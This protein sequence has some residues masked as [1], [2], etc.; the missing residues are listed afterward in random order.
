MNEGSKCFKNPF[1]MNIAQ[2]PLV[3]KLVLYCSSILL[4]T[5][6]CQDFEVEKLGQRLHTWP[7]ALMKS[8]ECENFFREGIA[9]F[10]G[11]E[12]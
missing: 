3:L 8:E 9:M 2:V 11:L 7:T 12:T 1:K 4:H 10:L 5:L 6:W